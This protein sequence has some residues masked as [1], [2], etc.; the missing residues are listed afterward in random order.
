ML[1]KEINNLWSRFYEEAERIV[2]DFDEKGYFIPKYDLP[3]QDA[4]ILLSLS[5]SSGNVNKAYE[6]YLKFF[7]Q[8]ESRVP[9]LDIT[10]AKERIEEKRLV[11]EQ[12]KIQ[13]P[14]FLHSIL[15]DLAEGRRRII[16]I[17]RKFILVDEVDLQKWLEYLSTLSIVRQSG[18]YWTLSSTRNLDEEIESK[19][20]ED[21]E[22]IDEQDEYGGTLRNFLAQFHYD[23]LKTKLEMI[24]DKF[25]ENLATYT[26]HPSS[27]LNLIRNVAVYHAI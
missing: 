27:S 19:V 26:S 8:I 11:N 25:K 21:P 9:I 13:F 16:D 6:E 3:E 2:K 15:E 12:W 24:S 7:F 4:T 1:E 23:E 18:D 17:S 22:D 20:V 5:L 14:T 10:R